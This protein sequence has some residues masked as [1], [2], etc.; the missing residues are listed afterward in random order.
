MPRDVLYGEK[1]KRKRILPEMSQWPMANSGRERKMHFS[2]P[3][4]GSEIMTRKYANWM[5]NNDMKI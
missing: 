2:S 4:I 1:Q 3:K 5:R